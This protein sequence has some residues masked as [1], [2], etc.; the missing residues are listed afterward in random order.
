MR[1]LFSILVLLALLTSG[2]NRAAQADTP[3]TQ[4]GSLS[5]YVP[6]RTS[7][8]PLEEAP[9]PP[10]ANEIAMADHLLTLNRTPTVYALRGRQAGAVI[11]RIVPVHL[12]LGAALSPRVKF[13]AGVDATIPGL[14]SGPLSARVD[15]DAIFAVNFG[16]VSTL[17]PLTLDGIYSFPLPAGTRIYV[18]AG[19]GPYFGDVTRFG[20]KIL[21]G[22]SLTN[23]LGVEATAHFQGYGDSI[24]TL[25]LRIP[26]G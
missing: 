11:G 20:G 9:A 3:T 1:A 25:A 5:A 13:D 14:S 7:L 23:A 19:I 2:S 18:G 17:V 22:V 6:L 10:L 12:R 21:A 16:G 24:F 26:L 15:L 8:P 4:T